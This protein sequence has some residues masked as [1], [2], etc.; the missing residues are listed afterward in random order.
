[1]LD[2]ICSS[3]AGGVLDAGCVPEGD[4]E[5]GRHRR[6]HPLVQGRGRVV[7]EVDL[8]LT[9]VIAHG[10]TSDELVAGVLTTRM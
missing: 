5:E 10:A 9:A 2:G 3:A 6:E 4:A 8:L 7:V 1:L